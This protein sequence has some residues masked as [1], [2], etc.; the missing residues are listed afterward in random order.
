MKV[1][2]KNGWDEVMVLG[3]ITIRLTE[4][5]Q[6]LEIERNATKNR[7]DRVYIEIGG[8]RNGIGPDVDVCDH[9]TSE[10]ITL[11]AEAE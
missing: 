1:E 3:D 9:N 2:T 8:D 5:G 6:R 7:V 11:R 4:D 10:R